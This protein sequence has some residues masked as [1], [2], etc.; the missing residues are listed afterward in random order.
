[1]A[2]GATVVRIRS[3]L[4]ILTAFVLLELVGG[5]GMLLVAVHLVEPKPPV[6]D[7]V[8][9]TPVRALR[10]A[11]E[12]M[13]TELP[14]PSVNVL[15][16]VDHCPLEVDLAPEDGATIEKATVK[17]VGWLKKGNAGYYADGRH[18]QGP[19][20]VI[21]AC[22]CDVTSVTVVAKGYVIVD[23]H[24]VDA[25]VEH[26][27]TV[28]L[29]RGVP[30]RGTVTD[31]E[32]TPIPGAKIRAGSAFAE[33]KVDGSYV[34]HA[35]PEMV[36][37]VRASASGFLDGK[38]RLRFDPNTA[39]DVTVDL[40][41]K[42]ARTVTVW[43][44]GLPDDSCSPVLGL[45]CTYPVFPFGEPCRGDP[46]VCTCPEGRVAIR[47]GGTS[48]E[49]LPDETEAW[50]DLRSGGR[51]VGAVTENDAPA[52]CDVVGIRLPFGIPDLKNGIVAASTGKC[53]SEGSFKLSGLAPGKW[54]V[55]VRHG[56]LARSL[57]AVVT[58]GETETDVGLVD[59][60]GGGFI[61]GV[62]IDAL[63]EK[64]TPGEAVSVMRQGA[65]EDAP[66]FHIAISAS[67]G[68]FR[69]RGLD[70]GR[71]DVFLST[72]PFTRV[73]ATVEDGQCDQEV[74]LQTGE[75]DLLA[76][77]GFALE[78]DPMGDLVVSRVEADGSA[79]SNGLKAGDRVDGI[80]LGGIDPGSLLPGLEDEITD[81]VLDHWSSGGVTLVVA[82][83]GA[84][85]E[86]PLE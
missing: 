45:T 85:V 7:L 48:V 18:E 75:A 36:R 15:D 6:P 76:N 22:P 70:D 19:I 34:L 35:D 64:G 11:G 13:P 46:T 3:D 8:G 56:D 38:E 32:G 81:L 79:A 31:M 58:A 57:Y 53:T 25:A 68:R 55:E 69:V 83:D 2:T 4:A 5:I 59:L 73:S 33:T 43:C 39:K 16:G 17:A 9:T 14:D 74:R 42:R 28:P 10:Q 72:R 84:S 49:V 51:I 23:R 82:R 78:S 41:L 12:E 40:A 65:P 66:D 80:L 24:D 29:V 1:L 44:A 77:N 63:T 30:I 21:D 71:Y 52:A 67:Q 47:G 37:E 54:R 26:F 60:G 50:L 86:V 62:V 61:E 20:W 27:I